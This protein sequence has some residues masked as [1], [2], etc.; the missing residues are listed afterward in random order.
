MTG[1]ELR[2][3]P[4]WV[5]WRGNPP[6]VTIPAATRDA[7]ADLCDELERLRIEADIASI[8]AKAD[9]A[10]IRRLRVE[11]AAMAGALGDIAGMTPVGE[12]G[13]WRADAECADLHD[14]IC[15][16]RWPEHPDNW[17]VTCTAEIA[18]CAWKMGALG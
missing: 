18:W 8:N 7:L 2:A 5:D 15:H 9:D 3:V 6:K 10:I 12:L 4:T 13:A 14:R 16:T 1:D 11:N 17:C